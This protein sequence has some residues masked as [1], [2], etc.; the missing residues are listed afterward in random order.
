VPHT[1]EA[2]PRTALRG[3]YVLLSADTLRLLVPQNEVG[4]AEYLETLLESADEPGLLR[5]PGAEN[6]RR[7]AALSAKMTLL[8]RCPANRFI[9]TSLG[10]E[11]DELG[12]CWNEL[13]VLIDVKLWPQ[14]LPAVL[15]APYT[16]VEQY[17]ELA[18]EIAYLCS[19]R[20]LR[21]FAL[22]SGS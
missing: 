10:L 20:R 17:V 1:F 11:D 5:R 2:G 19:A 12:W 4:A 6:T 7:F 8:P 21:A 16:P 9:V 13:K 3:N 15:R 22:S 18:G 14:P